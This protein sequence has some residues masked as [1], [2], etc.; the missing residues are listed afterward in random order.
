MTAF[1][2]DKDSQAEDAK[3]SL[4]SFAPI[5]NA[6]MMNRTR[7]S[8]K[9]RRTKIEVLVQNDTSSI[10]SQ[11]LRRPLSFK[12]QEGTV[13]YITAITAKE[14]LFEQP[15][16]QSRSVRIRSGWT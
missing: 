8:T 13:T 6:M 14:L 16:F 3:H 1:L 4:T 7:G 5:P 11:Q 15:F 2:N 10:T 12:I 9:I